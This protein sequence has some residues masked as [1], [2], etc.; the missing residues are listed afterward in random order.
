MAGFLLGWFGHLLSCAI[1]V[2]WNLLALFSIQFMLKSVY[3]KVPELAEREQIQG[4]II[5][6][7]F[8]EIIFLKSTGAIF[9][10][11]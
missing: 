1:V 2:C 6:R 11:L 7:N 3:N 8:I 5:F 10:N 9:I 4:W